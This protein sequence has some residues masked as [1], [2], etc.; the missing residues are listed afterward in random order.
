[1]SGHPSKINLFLLSGAVAIFLALLV[2]AGLGG[3]RG[4]DQH[5][6]TSDAVNIAHLNPTSNRIFPV[7]LM[8]DDFKYPAPLIHN[9][10]NVY[11]AALPAALFGGYW[12]WLILNGLLALLATYWIYRASRGFCEPPAATLVALYFLLNPLTF[13]QASQPLADLMIA[14]FAAGAVYALARAGI[15]L[16]GWLAATVMVAL[17]AFSRQNFVLLLPCLPLGYLLLADLEDPLALRLR[18]AALLLVLAAGLGVAAV[19]FLSASNVAMT[20]ARLLSQVGPEHSN[21]TYHAFDLS[22]ANLSNHIEI[23][24]GTL[25]AKIEQGLGPQF[26]FEKPAN[27]L[28]YWAFNLLA[29]GN[30]WLLLWQRRVS[31]TA[32]VAWTAA[33][34]IGLHL[35]TVVVHQNQLR[36]MLPAVPA[37][38]VGFGVLLQQTGWLARLLQ[39]LWVPA[40][41]ALLVA[42]LLADGRLARYSHADGIR[43]GRVVETTRELLRQ[44]QVEGAVMVVHLNQ[45]D[46][47]AALMAEIVE[48]RPAMLVLQDYSREQ[49]RAMLAKLPAK[50]LLAPLDTPIPAILGVQGAALVEPLPLFSGWGL[51]TLAPEPAP[52]PVKEPP[53]RISSGSRNNPQS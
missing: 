17:M 32:V 46:N 14:C 39:R 35:L 37:L 53:A 13:W 27:A 18:R 22:N 47:P 9:N 30:L 1:M 24:L 49:Y 41:L 43:E 11:I 10:I 48:P 21:N 3:E 12:G 29:L 26:S 44:H 2:Y 38:L 34:M 42:L 6:Y 5:L 8:S 15:A 28:L 33:A 25:L 40:T 50:W 31:R 19:A 4:T 51:F 20:P 7:Y 52:S 23:G 36:Y 16:N 45:E